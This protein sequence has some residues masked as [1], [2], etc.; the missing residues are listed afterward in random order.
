MIG[1]SDL[2]VPSPS[3]RAHWD[4]H[5]EVEAVVTQMSTIPMPMPTPGQTYQVYTGDRYASLYKKHG[6]N[7]WSHDGSIGKK[8]YIAADEHLIVIAVV[9]FSGNSPT[10]PK[11]IRFF[12]TLVLTQEGMAWL[13]NVD[14]E[15]HR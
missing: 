14:L 8:A 7:T 13:C 11:D 9:E 2:V 15:D 12:N 3:A 5:Q 10:P 6:F 1:P 4:T